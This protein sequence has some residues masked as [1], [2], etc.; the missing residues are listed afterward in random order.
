[1]KKAKAP[2]YARFTQIMV[3]VLSGQARLSLTLFVCSLVAVLMLV[4]VSAQVYTT[5]LTQE[6]AD[7]KRT[8][9][10]FKE[11]LNRLTSEYVTL[12]SGMR[13]AEHCRKQHMVPATE[14]CL[15]RY[16]VN[17]ESG[18]FP[19]PVDFTSGKVPIPASYRFTL[20]QGTDGRQ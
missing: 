3:S 19:E 6:I 8:E 7:L 11:T 1:M 18:G 16:A 14:D 20:N 12:S 15:V 13:V 5:T 10:G 9:S 4:Y 17:F 2:T